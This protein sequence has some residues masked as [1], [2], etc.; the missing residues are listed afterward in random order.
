MRNSLGAKDTAKAKGWEHVVKVVR[1][2][3]RTDCTDGVRVLIF[4]AE[5]VEGMCISWVAV[6]ACEVDSDGERHLPTTA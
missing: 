4:G 5:V 3:D 6:R 2:K 1:F